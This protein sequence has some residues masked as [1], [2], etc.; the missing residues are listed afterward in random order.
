MSRPLIPTRRVS[1]GPICVAYA[2]SATNPSLT[3]RVRKNAAN[4][5]YDASKIKENETS[6]RVTEGTVV[7]R[8]NVPAPISRITRETR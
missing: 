4:R 1:E 3:R 2:T 5:V 6:K 8:V 7:E